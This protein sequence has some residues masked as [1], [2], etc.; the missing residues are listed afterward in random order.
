M[1][2][3]GLVFGMPARTASALV[4]RES[5]RT[6][7]RLLPYGKRAVPGAKSAN[8][9]AF[10]KGRHRGRTA[11]TRALLACPKTVAATFLRGFESSFTLRMIAVLSLY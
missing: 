6:D 9:P 8:K 10:P 3:F 7:A 5:V 11:L 1:S 2:V 4:D